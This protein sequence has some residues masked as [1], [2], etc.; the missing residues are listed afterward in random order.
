MTQICTDL[1]R[2]SLLIGAKKTLITS[3]KKNFHQ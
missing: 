1:I 2:E 3:G